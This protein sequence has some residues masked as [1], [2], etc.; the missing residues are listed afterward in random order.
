MVPALMLSGCTLLLNNNNA[1]EAGIND[2]L[3]KPT[4]TINSNQ[5]GERITKEEA[6]DKLTQLTSRMSQTVANLKEN[7]PDYLTYTFKTDVDD[8][9][10]FASLNYAKEEQ[11]VKTHTDQFDP[12]ELEDGTK[13]HDKVT[14]DNYLY[15]DGDH[16]IQASHQKNES[17]DGKNVSEDKFY[18]VLDESEIIDWT[19]QAEQMGNRATNYINDYRQYL[20]REYASADVVVEFASKGEGHLYAYVDASKTLGAKVEVLFDNYFLVYGYAYLNLKSVADWIPAEF[21]GK[22]SQLASELRVDFSRFTPEYPNLAEYEA[23]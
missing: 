9:Y 5:K 1:N 17:A 18:S 20:E 14:K 2:E 8:Q 16:Y 6:S 21:Q 15:L 3:Y 22:G 12:A 13:G 19:S 23:E 4:I 10:R 7:A 11:Y